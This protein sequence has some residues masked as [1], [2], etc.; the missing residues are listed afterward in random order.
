AARTLHQG[1]CK[2]D[3]SAGTQNA[4]G[5]DALSWQWRNGLQ[6]AIEGRADLPQHLRRRFPRLRT[7]CHERVQFSAAGAVLQMPPGLLRQDGGSAEARIEQ[8]VDVAATPDM[9][10]FRSHSDVL[11][12]WRSF[13]YAR[14]ARSF[15]APTLDDVARATSSSVIPETFSISTTSR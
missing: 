11:R 1:N 12:M 8:P 2:Y 5:N 15:T 13:S 6:V 10:Q 4:S 3:Q 9:V 14:C 7:G